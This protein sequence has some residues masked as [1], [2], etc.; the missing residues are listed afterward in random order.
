MGAQ[1]VLRNHGSSAGAGNFECKRCRGQ[2]AEDEEKVLPRLGTEKKRKVLL[3]G[4]VVS[5][6]G[7]VS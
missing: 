5:T 3:S 4:G 7:E 2:V 1:A 6:D